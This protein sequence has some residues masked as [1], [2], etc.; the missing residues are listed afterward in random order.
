VS[1]GAGGDAVAQRVPVGLGEYARA[2][3]LVAWSD[4]DEVIAVQIHVALQD[5]VRVPAHAVAAVA[6]EELGEELHGS[7]VGLFVVEASTP[8]WHGRTPSLIATTTAVAHPPGCV[9]RLSIIVGE[10]PLLEDGLARKR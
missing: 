2:V 9:V 8:L 6:P 5:V 10:R 1:A 4:H 7:F 3:V